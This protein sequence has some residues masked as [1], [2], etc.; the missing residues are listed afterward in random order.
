MPFARELGLWPEMDWDMQTELVEPKVGEVPIRRR[1]G[2]DCIG[3]VDVY[4][5]ELLGERKG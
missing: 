2:T 5:F 1:A 3:G 4:H